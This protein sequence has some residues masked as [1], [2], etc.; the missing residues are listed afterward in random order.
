MKQA[1]EMF[2][3]VFLGLVSC[4]ALP[5]SQDVSDIIQQVVDMPSLQA[6]YHVDTI[7][8]RKPLI[9]VGDF[10]EL[11]VNQFGVPVSV[12]STKQ[13]SAKYPSAFLEITMLQINGEIAKVTFRYV[14]EGV[15]GEAI[16]RKNRDWKITKS[17]L[18]ER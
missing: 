9:I 14:P 2:L 6:F 18:V 11:S 7:P 8:D 1:A 5:E 10:D 16:L 15:E 17:K 4:R 13:A 12:L 3:L